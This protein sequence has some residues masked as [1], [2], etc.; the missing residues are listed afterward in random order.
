MSR[1]TPAF[2]FALAVAG[3]Y[4]LP[5]S[6]QGTKQDERCV[7]GA[8]SGPDT[9]IAVCTE[10]LKPGNDGAQQIEA[11]LVRASAYAKKAQGDLAVADFSRVIALDGDNLAALKARAELYYLA[12][13]YDRAIQ[14]FNRVIRIAPDDSKIFDARGNAFLQRGAYDRAIQDS[15]LMVAFRS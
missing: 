3:A 7:A 8:A 13:Q 6:A 12:Y 10:Q 2:L 5:A 4:A 1:F 9:L 15:R 11:L 14:D